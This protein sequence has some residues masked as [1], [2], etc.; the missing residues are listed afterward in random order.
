MNPTLIGCVSNVT[1][2]LNGRSSLPVSRHILSV[3]DVVKTK[4]ADS[5]SI[6][7]IYIHLYQHVQRNYT[8]KI[9]QRYKLTW[10]CP[11]DA[12]GRIDEVS[13]KAAKRPFCLHSSTWVDNICVR[14]IW[15]L[16]TKVRLSQ[17]RLETSFSKV[18]MLES[19]K[20]PLSCKVFFSFQILD[21]WDHFDNFDL[22]SIYWFRQGRLHG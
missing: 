11:R 8:H 12:I 14:S 2:I 17:N 22:I 4:C 13:I 21:L 7:Y 9:L 6:S 10:Y 15:K 20:H 16:E 18:K 5:L 3:G 19:C 1:C